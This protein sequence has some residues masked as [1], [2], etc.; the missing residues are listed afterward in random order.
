M[1]LYTIQMSRWRK[2]KELGIT[3]YDITI[4][5][6][7]KLFAPT[8]DMLTEYKNNPDKTQREKDYT[9]KYHK[10]MRESY[11]NNR[12]HWLDLLQNESLAIACYCSSKEGTFCHR[13]LLVK[14]L[15][16]VCEQHNLKFEYKGELV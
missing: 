4:K 2:A 15:K 10:L 13:H 16:K 3:F 5:S 6:G 12:Q 14:Y 9:I 7:D 1:K 8:W 11:K